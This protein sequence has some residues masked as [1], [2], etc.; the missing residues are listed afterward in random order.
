MSI[1]PQHRAVWRALSRLTSGLAIALLLSPVALA[2]SDDGTELK[3]LL[4]NLGVDS[5]A[6]ARA[7]YEIENSGADFEFEVKVED[8][9]PGSYELYVGADLNSKG[10]LV[11]DGEGKGEIEFENP[12]DSGLLL[13]FT[14]LGELIQIRQGA[15]VFFS[16]VFSPGAGSADDIDDVDDKGKT[17]KIKAEV[18]MTNVGSDFD[19]EGEVEF[20]SNKGEMEFEVK[21]KKLDPG[22]YELR[23]G[24][25]TVSSHVLVEADEI[26]WEFESPFE[27]EGDSDGGSDELE[28][29]LTF[30]PLGKQ[31]DV[32]LV[33][34]ILLTEDVLLTVLMPAS[35]ATTGS[36]PPKKGKNA[37]DI[38][39][40]KGDAL[41]MQLLDMGVMP[42]AE[43]EAEFEQKDDNEDEFEVKI[44]SVPV[45]SYTLLVD[46][47]VRGTIVVDDGL[48]PE[49]KIKFSTDP[50]GSEQLLDFSVPGK[51]IEVQSAGSTV[52]SIVFPTSVQ[53]ATGKLKKEKHDPGKIKVNLISTGADF[54]T[55]GLVDYKSKNG[56]SKMKVS[57]VDLS[58]GTYTVFVDGVEQGTLAITK[59]DGKAKLDFDSKL[60]VPKSNGKKVPLDFAVEGL[61]IE[62]KD[63][64]G[65]LVLQ[66]VVA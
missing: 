19:A 47:V 24:G 31:I 11:V 46:N 63:S 17:I 64:L 6:S 23:V 21:A 41:E 51:L 42:G 35:P 48:D 32:V 29:E 33:D 65:V 36:K 37:K 14:V 45:G 60:T 12:Q 57:I 62:I 26:K 25:Q 2:K 40:N 22:T 54:D 1:K 18:Y 5:D 53:V 44:E 66:V 10:T 4:T 55:Y 20:E 50:G 34:P 16:S 28:A 39:K 3:Q 43:G 61:L 56:K 30:D 52:L 49:G 38:G 13:D 15:T 7:E 9:V 27:D 58:I 8:L 59:P